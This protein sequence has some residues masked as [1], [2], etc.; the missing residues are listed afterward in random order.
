MK[1]G[2]CP[3]C[4]KKTEIHHCKGCGKEIEFSNY[5]KLIRKKKAP[6]LCPSCMNKFE[7]V[8]C[9]DC[10]KEIHYYYRQKYI[11]NQPVPMICDECRT[12]P[13]VYRANCV[14]CGREFH[15]RANEANFYNERELTQPKRCKDCRSSR[16]YGYNTPSRTYTPAPASQQRP[17]SSSGTYQLNTGSRSRS[18]QSNKDFGIK[19]FI[20]LFICLAV[21]LWMLAG[22][23]A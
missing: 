10:G 15:M 4:L 5:D 13:I 12:N 11:Y 22:C 14:D 6:V 2:I 3:D 21:F 1:N 23:V 18:Y 8:R 20:Y 9:R 17:R 7:I 16:K 19:G